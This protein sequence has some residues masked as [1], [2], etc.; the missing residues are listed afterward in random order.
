MKVLRVNPDRP[1]GKKI[2]KAA[3]VIEAGELVVYPTETVYGLGANV[4]ERKAILRVFRIKERDL[5]DPISI[6]VAGVKR[7]KELVLW[8]DAAERL[9]EEF[10]PGPLTLILKGKMDFPKGLVKEGKVGIR[11][12]KH[13]I[14]LALIRHGNLPITSTSA[15]LSGHTSPRTVKEV[16]DQLDGKVDLIL[17]SGVCRIG[18]PST[19]IDLTGKPRILRSGPINKRK[20]DKVLK[21]LY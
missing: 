10:L 14:A 13:P 3:E 17:D 15:N 9:A 19:V 2:E 1:E 16:V 7:A 12:P 18:K 6:A 8:N 11:I 4:F 5:N 20:I 21:S